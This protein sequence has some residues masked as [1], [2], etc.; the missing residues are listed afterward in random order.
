MGYAEL[1][2]FRVDRSLPVVRIGGRVLV[3]SGEVER[4]NGDQPPWSVP[5]GRELVE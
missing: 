5:N 2:P 4:L 3:R 1:L